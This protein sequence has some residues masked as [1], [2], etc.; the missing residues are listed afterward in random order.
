MTPFLITERV[1]AVKNKED[2]VTNMIS[3]DTNQKGYRTYIFFIKCILKFLSLFNNILIIFCGIMITH[4]VVLMLPVGG[5]ACS[6]LPLSAAVNS[7]K[8]PVHIKE[9][10]E[11]C[12]FV[13]LNTRYYPW[14]VN[15]LNRRLTLLIN[16]NSYY[17][18]CVTVYNEVKC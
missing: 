5:S 3:L 17:L 12:T 16:L 2:I 13:V 7:I 15:T 14:I 9:S 18:A 11:I 1:T 6:S 4:A 8:V 10:F